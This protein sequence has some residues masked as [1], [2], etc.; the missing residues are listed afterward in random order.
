MTQAVIDHLEAIQVEEEHRHQRLGTRGPL[1]RVPGVL[2]PGV[3]QGPS[4][5]SGAVDRPCGRSTI[6]DQG[7]MTRVVDPVS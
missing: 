6:H 5:V 2:V 7:G 4:Q 1:Q 3:I